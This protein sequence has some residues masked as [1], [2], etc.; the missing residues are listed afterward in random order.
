MT[1]ALPE[2]KGLGHRKRPPNTTW[3][4][5]VAAQ[6]AVLAVAAFIYVTAELAPVGALPAIATDLQVGEAVV[7]TLVASYA[8]VAAAMTVP[9]VRA[10]AH[11]SRRRTL[12]VTLIT[13]TIA[14]TVSA[15]APDLLVLAAG[16]VSCALTHGLMWSVIAPIGVRLVPPSHAGRATTV[17][18]VGSAVALVVGSPLTAAM[19][20]L[21]GWRP[22][23]AVIAV[24]A[25]CV[26]VAARLLLPPMDGGGAK[27]VR[28][29]RPNGRLLTLCALTVIGVS[30]HFISYTF[31]VVIIRDVV[32]IHGAPLAWLLASYGVAGLTTMA[33]MARPLDRRPRRAVLAGLGGMALALVALA[34]LAVGV[35]PAA[36]ALIVGSL[37]ILLWGAM[38]TALPP[39]L[40]SAAI[41]TTRDDSDGASGWYVTAFQIGIM[42]G[43]LVGGLIYESA[44]IAVMLATSA[45]LVGAAAVG[46]ITRRG[47]FDA[48]GRTPSR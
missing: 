14:Q 19:S 35:R 15:L 36:A 23:F 13:L 32:G 43:S 6:L 7:G 20:Q 45:L 31:I 26:T 9:L 25:A 24:A 39:M 42:A 2:A 3:T 22:S 37:A 38:A 30:A 8:F 40:Q 17:I 5:R 28:R 10:T 12:V 47:L 33:L 18:Y 46:V 48:Q 16:R 1:V 21:W 34:V 41:C 29:R 11:W 44:G 27:P 4:P